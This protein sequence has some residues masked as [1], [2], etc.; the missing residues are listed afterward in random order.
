MFL[1]RGTPVPENFPELR[2][3]ECVFFTSTILMASEYAAGEGTSSASTSGYVQKY[4]IRRPRLFNFKEGRSWET[5]EEFESPSK[6]FVKS[7]RD[8]GYVGVR[9]GE[10]IYLFDLEGL[11][12][13]D[14]WAV[15]YEESTDRFCY[16]ESLL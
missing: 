14:R 3:Y 11:H 9:A 10:D 6:G 12:L 13:L 1:Y 16:S 15:R 8:V 5:G 4:A 7:L 2:N